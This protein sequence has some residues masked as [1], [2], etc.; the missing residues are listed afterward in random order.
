MVAGYL[1][2]SR[3]RLIPILIPYLEVSVPGISCSQSGTSTGLA[4]VKH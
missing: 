4:P 2:R 1:F 3:G